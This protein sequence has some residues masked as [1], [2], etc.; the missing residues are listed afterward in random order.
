MQGDRPCPRCG[1]LIPIGHEECPHCAKPR[2]RWQVERE[3][4]L[5]ISIALLAILFGITGVAASL[6]HAGRQSLAQEWFV[7][8]ELDL[9]NKDAD[10]ALDDFRTALAYSPDTTLFRL[11]LAQ[12]L[13]AMGRPEEARSHLLTL[14][15][16]EP[17]NSTVNLE[18]ARLAV[19]RGDSTD[20][21][22][23]FHNA[24]YGVWP[25]NPAAH[26]LQT[27]ME[28]CEYL[29]SQH[30]KAQAQSE[31]IALM[32]EI[33]P[34]AALYA[35]IAGMLRE[36]G[37]RNRA[38]S[39]Y[40]RALEIDKHHGGALEGAGETAFALGEYRIAADYLQRALRA[41][42]ASKSDEDMVSTARLV[43]NLDPMEPRLSRAE[44]DQR[45]LHDFEF[46][47]ARLRDCLQTQGKSSAPTEGEPQD[48]LGKLSLQAGQLKS[49]ATAETLRKNPDLRVTL[50]DFVSN[51]EETTAKTCGNPSGVD[52]ALLLM[53]RKQGTSER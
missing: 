35:R 47:S 14:W 40:R 39:A 1:Q 51:V 32:A 8:G 17:G 20:A 7:R 15:R 37:D 31:L 25:S 9:K 46:A 29:L 27:R 13:V 6:Y 18:L 41:G 5:L 28:L 23:Y 44:A 38:L 45:T 30:Q 19:Q 53:G 48:E 50:M 34:D 22:R 42:A 21:L 24:I 43:L 4:L 36:A 33:P 52:L 16:D 12:A 2:G 49:S 26:R 11:R 3:T 10:A